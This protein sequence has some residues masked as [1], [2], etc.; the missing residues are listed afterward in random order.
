MPRITKKLVDA[1][2][3]SASEFTLWDSEL[4]GFGL[5][6]RPSGA[7]SSKPSDITRC[8]SVAP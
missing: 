7:Q 2:Q 1:A 6:V 8:R 3:P 5:R 4:K